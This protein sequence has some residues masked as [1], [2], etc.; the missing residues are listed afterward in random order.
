MNTR[1]ARTSCCVAALAIIAGLI[2]VARALASDP[3][4]TLTATTVT[5]T[6]V[7]TSIGPL[8][9]G[10]W[11]A[12][13]AGW[14]TLPGVALTTTVPSGQQAIFIAR[15]SA[16]TLCQFRDDCDVRFTINGQPMQ[17]DNGL[18]DAAAGYDGADLFASANDDSWQHH[19]R[20]MIRA[21]GPYPAGTYTIRAQV[22][23]WA[24]GEPMGATLELRDWQFSVQRARS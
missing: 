23:L 22:L 15:L 1:R 18:V 16:H 11:S 19:I 12:P 5:Q 4:H 10:S 24:T 17:P 2:G 21:A 8:N 13:V 9:I 3:V 14:Q 20:T 6:K 7:K